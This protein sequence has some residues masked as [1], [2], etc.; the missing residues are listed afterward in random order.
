MHDELSVLVRV[1]DRGSFAAAATDLG[2]SNSA[3]SKVVT[4][5]EQRL[6]VRLLHRTT[7]RLAMTPEGELFVARAREIIDAVADAEAEISKASRGPHGRLRVNCTSGFAFHQLSAALPQFI[8]L[9]PEVRVELSVTDRVVDLLAENADVGLRSGDVVAPT[10]VVRKIASFER[11]L[12]ASPGYLAKN[13]I[14][15][16]PEDLAAHHVCVVHATQG[17]AKW[18][19]EVRGKR[20][21]VTVPGRLQVDNAEAALRLAMAGA[22]VARVAEMMAVS[23]VAERKLVPVL[24]EFHHTDPVAFS[25]VYPSGR[26]RMLKVRVFLDFLAS[27]FSG[28]RWI[29]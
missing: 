19:F 11:R 21:D 23:A 27:H 13:G 9:Y 12:Y 8:G 1:V 28:S 2:L 20:I 10:L 18:P 17:A 16:S 14:P 7:R 26:L 15:A 29:G 4:R 24:P 5:L 22:G 6:G 25:A 3:V